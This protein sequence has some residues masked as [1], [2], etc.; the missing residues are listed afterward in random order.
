MEFG[1]KSIFGRTLEDP[2]QQD[3]VVAAAPLAPARSIP[4]DR[5]ERLPHRLRRSSSRI[6]ETGGRI[7][8][9]GLIAAIGTTISLWLA[10]LVWTRGLHEG[11]VIMLIGSGLLALFGFR[12]LGRGIYQLAATVTPEASLEIDV[13]E[14]HPGDRVRIFVVQPGPA[15]LEDL[16]VAL[17]CET[18]VR[19]IVDGNPSG[20]NQPPRRVKH[21][22][23]LTTVNPVFREERVRIPRGKRYEKEVVFSVPA[24]CEC[25]AASDVRRYEWSFEIEGRPRLW[26]D[27]VDRYPIVV[28]PRTVR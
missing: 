16:A 9:G 10:Y 20:L 17:M 2:Q 19:E 7:V 23:T 4:H 11:L 14:L 15:D 28:R 12:R 1:P 3:V 21:W 8:L 24:D 18:S 27:F 25:S 6:V 13:E 26:P 22:E 5:G